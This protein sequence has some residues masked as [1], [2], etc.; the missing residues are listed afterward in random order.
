MYNCNFNIS[1]SY[2]IR[3]TR[4]VL[5]VSNPVLK[6]FI[7]EDCY[8][9]EGYRPKFLVIVDERVA[10]FHEIEK[11]LI[12]YLREHKIELD[13]L[14][15]LRV[16]AGEASKNSLSL[17]YE[18]YSLISKYE[19]DRHSYIMSIGGGAV[20][21][22][23]GFVATTAH[24]GIKHIRIPTTVLAQNDAAIGVKN[25][26]NF[27]GLKNFIGTFSVPKIVINDFDFLKTLS[28]RDFISGYAEAIKISL[29]KDKAFFYWIEQ[30]TSKLKQRDET[31]VAYLIERTAR[32]H[33]DHFQ[34]SGDPFETGN[35]RPLDYGH[36]QA[37][38][39]EK[40]SN[41]EVLHGEAVGL[42]MYLDSLYAIKKNLISLKE[43]ERVLT[44]LNKIGLLV[45]KEILQKLDL[46]RL[47]EALNEFRA[48]LGGALSIP[49]LTEIGK[50]Q[51]VNQIDLIVY[52]ACV[53]SLLNNE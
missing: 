45:Q 22:F 53:E 8:L 17:L 9:H 51:D 34:N 46:M 39:I 25:A 2:N 7:Q 26:I 35:S 5:E 44:L 19:V 40:L 10:E 29:I 13:F 18:V 14:P 16:P 15:M 20:N 36:W 4:G 42:G 24:R 27:N 11:N 37:H 3:F 32:L 31:A 28:T 52:N 48:H 33:T 47:E 12:T 23:A 6:N 41:F 43:G 21:D 38:F 30:N 50:F 1:F 49:M